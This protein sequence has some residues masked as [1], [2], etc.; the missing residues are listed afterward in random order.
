MSKQKLNSLDRFRKQPGRLVLEAHGHC[1]VPAGC[2]GVVLRWRDPLATRPVV[3]H[4]YVPGRT[5]CY[6]DG[7]AV[8]SAGVE[9]APGRHVFS[10]AAD[11]T[12]R[13]AGVRMFAAA[14]P[15]RPP[16]PVEPPVRVVSADDGTWKFALAKPADD[17]TSV[18]FDD[19]AWPALTAAP[20]PRLA[21]QD[22]GAYAVR[23]CT[24]LRAVCLG[25]PAGH[26][27]GPGDVWVRKA[28]DVPAARP[29]PVEGTS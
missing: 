2:G 18:A 26:A 24:A 28:F 14:G 20:A 8:E 1:E 9:L 23:N 17:W 11:V 21:P 25:L 19:S 5:T 3:I 10:V 12:V 16:D 27:L 4:L 29:R 15:A 13:S 22:P 7:A 6:L